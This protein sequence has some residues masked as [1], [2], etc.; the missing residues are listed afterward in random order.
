MRSAL[1]MLGLRI[2]ACAAL[3]AVGVPTAAHADLSPTQCQTLQ[4]PMTDFSARMGDLWGEANRLDLSTL[5]QQAAAGSAEA[6]AIERFETARAQFI[7]A[8]QEFAE[9]AAELGRHL[10]VCSRR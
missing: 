7:P 10:R 5:K 9:A 4:R 1:S 3:I 2:A 8:V 6:A